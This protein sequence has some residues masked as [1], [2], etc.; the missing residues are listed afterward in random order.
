MESY[1][2]V[3]PLWWQSVHVQ[4]QSGHVISDSSIPSML[5][6]PYEYLGDTSTVSSIAVELIRRRV[7]AC[8]P[9]SQ[10]TRGAS[11]DGSGSLVRYCGSPNRP[12]D[13]HHASCIFAVAVAALINRT[14][15][16][17]GPSSDMPAPRAQSLLCTLRSRTWVHVISTHSRCS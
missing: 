1:P 4:V 6:L 12:F 10:R 17:P 11:R 16:Q 8:A 2:L 15:P 9:P 3:P 14:F 5:H 7:S 13:A